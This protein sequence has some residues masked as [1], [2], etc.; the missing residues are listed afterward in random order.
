[1]KKRT[2]ER[3]FNNTARKEKGYMVQMLKEIL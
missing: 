3:D 1:M 2:P